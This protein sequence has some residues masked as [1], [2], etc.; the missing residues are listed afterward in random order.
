M[1]VFDDIAAQDLPDS[2]PGLVHPGASFNATHIHR[3]HENLRSF[4]WIM[5]RTDT[6]SEPWLRLASDIEGVV[7]QLATA[8]RAWGETIRN[9]SGTEASFMVDVLQDVS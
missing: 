3:L 1:S 5:N 6:R 8:F 4:T 7:Q 2:N 9:L